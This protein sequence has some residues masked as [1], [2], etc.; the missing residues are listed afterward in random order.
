MKKVLLWASLAASVIMVLN[1][2]IADGDKNENKNWN[3]N[4]NQNELR[5]REE[6]KNKNKK[7]GA[8]E[9]KKE[10]DKFGDLVKKCTKYDGLFTMYRDTVTGKTYLAIREDQL[11]KEYIYFNHIENAPPGTAI[12][13]DH[14]VV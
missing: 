13:K 9:P 5:E 10:E 6:E 3:E 14:S 4:K 2:G 1:L 7:K 11:N 12:S 8:E